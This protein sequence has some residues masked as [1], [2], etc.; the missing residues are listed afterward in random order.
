[1]EVFQAFHTERIVLYIG[2]SGRVVECLNKINMK[3]STTREHWA[4]TPDIQNYAY[5]I[6]SLNDFQNALASV[7]EVFFHIKVLL[8]CILTEVS[9]NS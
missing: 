2:C 3:Q 7:F 5:S 8:S 1:M 9:I 6:K 4:R